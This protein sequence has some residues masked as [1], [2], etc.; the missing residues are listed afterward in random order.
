[1]MRD[2]MTST[3]KTQPNLCVFLPPQPQKN[4]AKALWDYFL[5]N[6]QKGGET[7][8]AIHART[9]NNLSREKW[10]NYGWGRTIKDIFT[11]NRKFSRLYKKMICLHVGQN[12]SH[13]CYR[14]NGLGRIN[15]GN[16]LCEAIIFVQKLLLSK[17]E[18]SLH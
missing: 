7:N 17:F 2:N 14:W 12:F 4:Q 9:N 3:N 6:D 8:T 10:Y 5:F 11:S 13:V 16:Q 18:T 1:M 15:L